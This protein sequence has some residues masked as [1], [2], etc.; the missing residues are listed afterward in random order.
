MQNIAKNYYLIKE[1]SAYLLL[2]TRQPERGVVYCKHKCRHLVI[3]N[4][5]RGYNELNELLLKC[6][7]CKGIPLLGVIRKVEIIINMKYFH[8]LSGI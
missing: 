1:I 8:L 2:E 5:F 3:Q 7:Q 4:N 6:C